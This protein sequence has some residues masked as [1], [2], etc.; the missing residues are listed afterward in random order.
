[1]NKRFLFFLITVFSLSTLLTACKAQPT[2]VYVQGEEK[3]LITADA[4]PIAGHI[5]KGIETADHALFVS[6]FDDE[7]RTAMTETQFS[8][9][10]K[11]YG[12]LGAAQETE[13]INIE[14][15]DTYYRVNYKVTY[16]DKVVIMLVVLPQEEPRKVSGLWF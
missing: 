13:L 7:M 9:I 2:P 15:K 11:S 5:L 4:E 14:E 16:A 8:T 1:M 12:P 6:D 10:V 3:D